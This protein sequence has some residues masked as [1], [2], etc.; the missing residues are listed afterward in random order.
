MPFSLPDNI[1]DAIKNLPVGAQRI[2]VRVF[3]SVHADTKDEDKAR[4]AAWSAVKNKYEKVN[5]TWRKKAMSERIF[6]FVDAIDKNE[7][8][9]EKDGTATSEAQFFAIGKWQ[10]QQYGKIEFDEDKAKQAIKNYQN[11][12]KELNLDYNHLGLDGAPDEAIASGWL[13]EGLTET[14]QRGENK[15]KKG[16]WGIVRWTKK[17]AE[18]IKNGEYRFISPEFTDEGKDK[19]TGKKI[20]FNL[21]AA[22]LTNRPFLEG[23]APVALSERAL[24][25][26]ENSASLDEIL[27]DINAWLTKSAIP[28][29][30]KKGSPAI[31]LYLK[32]V[33][34]KLR[35]LIKKSK[36]TKSLVEQSLD[37]RRSQVSNAYQKQFVVPYPISQIHHW[38][39]EVFETHVI[40]ERENK[41]LK[42]P[43]T[44]KDDEVEFGDP[45]EVEQVY[46]ETGK[47]LAEKPMKTE[48]G[49][50]FPAEA[51]AYV[52]DPQKPSTWKLRLWEDPSKKETPKQ[53]GAAIAAFSPGGFR[54]RKVQIPT[55]DR[56]KV[57]AKI[58]AAWKRVN[59]DKEPED[60][61]AHIKST[62]GGEE[63]DRKLL[64]AQLGLSETA[65]DDEIT[66][67]L[68]RLK[69]L[70]G[71]KALIE[72]LGL[73]EESTVQEITE[74]VTKL[75]EA[76]SQAAAEGT[77]KL[78]EFNQLKN[79]HAKTKKLA[80]GLE[81]DK[82]ALNVKLLEK[83]RDEVIGKALTD[84]KL[85]PANK[86]LWEKQYMANPGE[87][88]ALL[89]A[90]PVVL[91]FKEHG[92][93]GSTG[94]GNAGEQL[95]IKCNEKMATNPKLSYSDAF[96]AAQ[97]ENP[98][99][100]KEYVK[101]CSVRA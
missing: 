53:V 49:V 47:K 76:G 74:A 62:E 52:P 27:G 45:V 36:V 61:P 18:Y 2:W 100:A 8:Q 29:K 54:G 80:E 37:D 70:Q 64:C 41:F 33:K 12:E 13:V 31:R 88:K 86:E 63:M 89:E 73:K 1:P 42:V 3:N 40:A 78:A 30:G 84:G 92:S 16:L 24:A 94:T 60:M 51:Y 46:Q 14:G 22:A 19:K 90:Q 99:L 77:V 17:A 65:T 26:V 28:L 93:G 87:T 97:T 32:G 11:A 69:E 39:M 6:R 82:D 96:K 85:V 75:K 9:F 79:D 48:D 10:H 58:R 35:E 5:D 95:S 83:E 50:Q 59:P 57:K 68:K 67:E 7:L 15:G 81:K 44:I 43:Y 23:M 25:E 71:H 34:E 4:I 72:S 38:V 55:E 20:G 66:A 21:L 91:D 98:E 56:G 101:E